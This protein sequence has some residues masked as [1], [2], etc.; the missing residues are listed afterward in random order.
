MQQAFR[1]LR[2]GR[3]SRGRVGW[4]QLLTFARPR[5]K[6]VRLVRTLSAGPHRR[7]A[8]M[9]EGQLRP[10][11]RAGRRLIG[12]AACRSREPERT[13]RVRATCGRLA[14]MPRRSAV[15]RI[16]A[17]AAGLRRSTSSSR[18]PASP[19]A[20]TQRGA[21]G[22]CARLLARHA[23]HR[24]ALLRAARHALRPGPRRRPAVAARPWPTRRSSAAPG[25][26]RG[27]TMG[28]RAGWSTG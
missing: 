7:E 9:A 20:R 14:R 4:P 11:D 21:D 16:A 10:G 12:A 6:A 15:R 27:S 13:T 2:A 25:R 17:R 8:L 1:M 23:L 24:A 19:A 22:L 5:W 3:E 26:W 18:P 28:R